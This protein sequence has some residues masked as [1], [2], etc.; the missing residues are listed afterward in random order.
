MWRKLP[1]YAYENSKQSA[2][3]HI[4]H[5]QFM[6][7]GDGGDVLVLGAR[8]FTWHNDEKSENKTGTF[9]TSGE[10]LSE[11]GALLSG[12]SVTTWGSV[13]V[14]GFA[15]R[16]SIDDANYIAESYMPLATTTEPSTTQR[17]GM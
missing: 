12:R 14:T 16:R 2:E 6:K 1:D 15:R 11:E 5:G 7:T 4:V 10:V 3:K 8:I 9:S 17:L 13:G